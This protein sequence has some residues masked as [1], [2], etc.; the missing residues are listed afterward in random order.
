MIEKGERRGRH[1][2]W[3]ES[4]VGNEALWGRDIR[5]GKYGKIGDHYTCADVF[6]AQVQDESF[7]SWARFTSG[8]GTVQH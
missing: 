5:W 3:E 6:I 4:R 2:Y 7:L 1:G 8:P